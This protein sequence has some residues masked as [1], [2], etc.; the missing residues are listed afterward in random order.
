MGTRKIR[1][2]AALLILIFYSLTLLTLLSE[3]GDGIEE[4]PSVIDV[5]EAAPAAAGV[6]E[7]SPPIV[8]S[9]G[10]IPPIEL[11][12]QPST[13]P[14]EHI[15]V[16]TEV[17][18]DQPLLIEEPVVMEEMPSADI[19][20]QSP[21]SEELILEEPVSEELL[22]FDEPVTTDQIVAEESF[23]S[24]ELI[25]D[26]KA[27]LI[28]D[29]APATLILDEPAPEA[30]P[31]FSDTEDDAFWDDFFVAGEEDAALFDEG[32]FYV[33]LIV[34]YDYLSDIMVTFD[35]DEVL[36][37]TQELSDLIYED[38][39]PKVR[40]AVFDGAGEHVALSYL[41][42]LGVE[43]SYD[44][45]SFALS[46]RFENWMMP[47]KKLSI[48]QGDVAK[49][50]TYEMSG[51]EELRPSLFSTFTNYSVHAGLSWS[52]DNPIE[53]T[54]ADLFSVQARSSMA[55]SDLSFDFSFLL[56]P[57]KGYSTTTSSWSTSLSDYFTWGG[58]VGFYDFIDTSVRL[59][60]GNVSEY[61]STDKGSYGIGLEKRYAY[62]TAQPNSHQFQYPIQIEVPSVVE[63]FI[64]DKSVYR[65]Q[66]LAGQYS[67]QDF[68]FSQG[69]NN[70]RVVVTSVD[71]P[72]KIDEYDFSLS[73][74][75]RLMA[76]G[77]T[78]YS[79]AVSSPSDEIS[80][81]FRLSQ[82]YGLMNTMTGGY[83]L[84]ASPSALYAGLNFILSTKAGTINGQAAGSLNAPLGFGWA[85][86]GSMSVASLPDISLL[87]SLSLN[88][89]YTNRLFTS[90]IEVPATTSPSSGNLLQ[91]GF[92]LS[93][94][95][96][97]TIKYSLNS[98]L[99]WY[100]NQSDLT[101]RTSLSA[102]FSL[103]KS[104]S[105]SASL[106]YQQYT[107]TAPSLTY[108]IGASWAIAKDASVA[109]S[110]NLESSSYISGSFRPFSSDNDSFRFT[111]SGIDFTD[112]L[113][114]QGS[115]FYSHTGT[116]SGLNLSGQY[117]DSFRS[118]NL[119]MN[120]TG[121][122]AYAGGLV[123]VGR[124]ISDS[125]LLV[126]PGGA[127]AHQDVAVT[128]TMT[129]DPQQLPSFLGTSLYSGLS[130]YQEN[131]I[132]VY[133]IGTDL[134]SSSES[135]IY[136]ANPRPRQG[137][138]VKVSS[139][140]AYSV[141]GTLLKTSTVPYDRYTV[142]IAKVE[143]DENGDEILMLDETLYLFTDETGFYF[144]SGLT[145]G[146]YQI[147]MFLPGTAADA[148]PVDIRFNVEEQGD[149]PEPKVLVLDTFIGEELALM[150]EDEAFEINIGNEVTDPVLTDGRYY[151]MEFTEVMNE[152]EFWDSYYPQR[153]VV[154]GF[155]GGAP[156][157]G[158]VFL[159]DTVPA[160]DTLSQSALAVM[161]KEN[162]LR[163]V[164]LSH[165]R[166]IV[167]PLIE[168]TAPEQFVLTGDV[169]KPMP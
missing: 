77:D 151:E 134:L 51:S 20:I 101:V 112:P 144:M 57:G 140:V 10:M 60:F 56:H 53:L 138:S 128:R 104:L 139:E 15:S 22:L 63:V 93:G 154:G 92:S 46:L 148:P 124:S 131:N 117:S 41:N 67:L 79:A 55:I 36:V 136:T 45:T 37:N 157:D 49:Y 1:A 33:P 25:T 115:L 74:D 90:S 114:H 96:I 95:I 88:F 87:G 19:I 83:S 141:V 94:S 166:D 126:R 72:E 78:L 54:P 103:I 30:D 129:T 81:R 43:G 7:T 48:N 18:V 149:G 106:S 28:I 133:G 119:S 61:L 34:N 146:Y 156:S 14:P 137:Y 164:N 130:P 97:D 16:E 122:V 99:S 89:A 111:F 27:E 69:A 107:A 110:T 84:A 82:T 75:S 71:D 147:S 38:L 5:V 70:T 98:S 40:K 150:L 23:F 168:A 64:N 21:V 29:D 152:T 9:E 31:F 62:G 17:I 165:L 155:D 12:G 113:N 6:E 32:S 76:V 125:F 108:Q 35:G 102:S 52:E 153:E 59:S 58:I 161:Y 145:P 50:G 159:I 42:A 109:A 132:V 85:A 123:G 8:D 44:Y 3:R 2:L 24:D 162:P 66:V 169:L 91:A 11:S 135:F 65:R 26:D 4:E 116:M 118:Y 160:S 158:D 121:A 13:P 100:T 163:L 47:I 167:L 86:T 73:Y 68:I 143:E 80:P 142:D 105:V 120:L 39:I 127:M